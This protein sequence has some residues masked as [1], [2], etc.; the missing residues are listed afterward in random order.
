MILSRHQSRLREPATDFRH[1]CCFA[2]LTI[3]PF[4]VSLSAHA[5]DE[6]PGTPAEIQ[7]VWSSVFYCQ[8]IYQEPEV[9]DRIYTGDLESCEK[10]DQLMRWLVSRRY[11]AK[12][13]QLLEQNARSKSR[14]IRYNTRSVQEAITACRQQC[15]QYSS[16]FDQRVESGEI[17]G[18]IE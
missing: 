1:S 5:G 16:I 4:L 18:V 3:I 13:R 11:S 6:L 8:E 9:K 7:D 12:D 2:L 17:P 15:R 10:S 14:A